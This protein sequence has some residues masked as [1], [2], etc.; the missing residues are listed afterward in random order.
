MYSFSAVKLHVFFIITISKTISK[1]M[2]QTR[3]S[4]YAHTRMDICTYAYRYTHIRVQIYAYCAHILVNVF[5]G[6]VVRK[7]INL[8][9]D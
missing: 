5:L 4:V 6:P 3:I 2:R 1:L 8:I 7:P 9:Q